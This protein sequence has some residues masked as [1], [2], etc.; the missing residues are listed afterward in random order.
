MT[1]NKQTSNNLFTGA[2]QLTRTWRW[3]AINKYY[4]YPCL[5][6]KKKKKNLLYLSVM[7]TW[8]N[9][10]CIGALED[11]LAIW[12]LRITKSCPIWMW[13]QS[14][15]L[16]QHLSHIK[17]HLSDIWR[18]KQERKERSVMCKEEKYSE[19]RGSLMAAFS[20]AQPQWETWALSLSPL[21]MLC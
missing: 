1:S 14:V 11:N 9:I 4:V 19:K 13:Q 17:H 6:L 18:T 20:L 16:L 10:H 2:K 12:C 15:A 3:G 21:W 7:T 8:K 5:I